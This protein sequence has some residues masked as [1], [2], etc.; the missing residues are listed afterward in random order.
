M[1]LRITLILG[2][3]LLD[4]LPKSY[5]NAKKCYVNLHTTTKLITWLFPIKTDES[6]LQSESR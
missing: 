2:S 6:R 3:T 4:K 1:Y 5:Y